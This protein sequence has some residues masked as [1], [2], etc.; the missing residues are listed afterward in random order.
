MKLLWG[1][2]FVRMTGN[3][4]NEIDLGALGRRSIVCLG[5]LSRFW[6]PGKAVQCYMAATGL[7]RDS[8]D[9]SLLQT[10]I[11][12]QTQGDQQVCILKLR[13]E[14]RKS[15]ELLNLFEN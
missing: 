8:R 11:A 5:L 9:F 1:A 12:K 4:L 2:K 3:F 13:F 6:T 10:N 15:L 7:D 14:K